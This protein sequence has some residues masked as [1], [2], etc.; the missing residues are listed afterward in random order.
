MK[1]EVLGLVKLESKEVIHHQ[2]KRVRERLVQRLLHGE[3]RGVHLWVQ[4]AKHLGQIN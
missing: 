3:V 1:E 2:G 4:V